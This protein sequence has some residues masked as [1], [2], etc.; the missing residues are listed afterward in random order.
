[1]EAPGGGAC[2]EDAGCGVAGAEMTGCEVAGCPALE[3]EGWD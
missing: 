1:M 3:T 2:S